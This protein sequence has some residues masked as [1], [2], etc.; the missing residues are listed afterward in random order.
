[1][2]TILMSFCNKSR[3]VLS[4]DSVPHPKVGYGTNRKTRNVL[5]NGFKK[6]RVTNPEE[7]D[8]LLMHNRRFCAEIAHSVSAAKRKAIRARCEQL[9]VRLTNG[10]AK[11]Q[12]E[13]NE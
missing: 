7:V 6:F 8:M 2:V 10:N 13:A 11:L 12:E 4:F 3:L 5:P 1:M 9:N